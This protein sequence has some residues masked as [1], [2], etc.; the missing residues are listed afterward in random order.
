MS[1]EDKKNCSVTVVDTLFELDVWREFPAGEPRT[2]P[3]PI[4]FTLSLIDA[5]D[6]VD[7]ADTNYSTDAVA[8]ADLISVDHGRVMGVMH[9]AG[10]ARFFNQSDMRKYLVPRDVSSQVPSQILAPGLAR[11]PA[12]M[13]V[14][15]PANRLE[16]TPEN[17]SATS[18]LQ[19]SSQKPP[20]LNMLIEQA[21]AGSTVHLDEI[22]VQ[23]QRKDQV[24]TAR[25]SV[26]CTPIINAALQA[27]GVAITCTELTSP[28]TIETRAVG[29]IAPTE[30]SALITAGGG[31]DE[32][33]RQALEQQLR[34]ENEQ[35]RDL[36]DSFSEAFAFIAADWRISHINAEGLR[37]SS[38]PL[39]S[40]I[41]HDVWEVW[42]HMRGTMV[43]TEFERVMRSG[44]SVNFEQLLSFAGCN[45]RW[46]DIRIYPT[47]RGGLAIFCRDIT[48][49]RDVQETLREAERQSRSSNNYLRLLLDTMTEGLCALDRSMKVTMC[50]T[51]LVRMFGFDDISQVIGCELHEQIHYAHA[52][53]TPYHR[54]DCR[55]YIAARDGASVSIDDEVFFRRDGASFPV[56]YRVRPVWQDGE[57]YG[58]MCT[59]CDIS[60]RKRS[61][62]AL[63]ESEQ[64]FRSLFA[65]HI[66]AILAT[67]LDGAFYDSNSMMHELTGYSHE[68]LC[69]LKIGDLAVEDDAS[70]VRAHFVLAIEGTSQNFQCSVRQ[71]NGRLLR[72]EATHIPI[73]IEGDVIGIFVVIRDVTAAKNY[74]R[75]IRY[76]ASHDALTGLP[77]RNLLDDRLRY[78]I[79]QRG[80]YLVGVLFLDLNRFKIINDSLGHDKGDLL[81]QIVAGRMKATLR[82]G[83][84]IARLGG[85]EFVVV[86]DK[87]EAPEQI[88]TTAQKL[89]TEVERS[90]NLEGHDVS[91]STSIGI[92]V[93]PKDGIDAD[94]LLKHA[95][96]AMYQAKNAGSGTFRFFSPEM[97][98]KTLERLL[99]ETGLRRVID[100]NELIVHYQPRINVLTGETVGVEAL[101]R[102][103]HPERGLIAPNDFIPLA[104]EIGMIG[105]IGE[106]VLRTACHQNREWQEAGLPQTKMSINLSAYQLLSPI[107][108]DTLAAI[109]R[110]S[111][112]DVKWIELEITETGLMQNIDASLDTLGKIH[113]MGISMSIDDFGTGYSS[114]SY[115]KKL[116][117]NTLKIDQSFIR[118]L[119]DQ[120]DDAV[121]VAATIG[122]AH[123]MGLQVVAEGVAT[124]EQAQFL[125]EKDCTTMQGYLFSKPLSA[126]QCEL[127]LRR[128]GALFR[129]PSFGLPH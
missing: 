114:L 129:H 94:T 45:D 111:G 43:E 83:D 44:Q 98:I 87:I 74:E 36:F 29:H 66:D 39:A 52:D 30:S 17:T 11:E 18:S 125:V 115:L 117:V 82:Q 6:A 4:H 53:G 40:V 80:K 100:R 56:E 70:L 50:N 107:F 71:K 72:V 47:L 12:N 8:D 69:A 15:T 112:L 23:L 124:I 3:Q 119:L 19:K 60:E 42:P 67:R 46:Y 41:G 127:F 88:A 126:S 49:H 38:H 24:T 92:A 33:V 84:T 73:I 48:P 10:C 90:I 95:D 99:N 2:W 97:N 79:N 59:F 63:K 54:D 89:L 37:L 1:F 7:A 105:A 64:H 110:D 35:S 34:F 21:R 65:H 113:A 9:G 104:E 13:P 61:E 128:E 32:L 118:D 58:A 120:P 27:C 86:L 76:L 14:N 16:S 121:I 85:D 122:L 108:V 57:L 5:V 55:M 78:A 109:V 96:L 28:T 25:F 102:W 68:E 123:S 93:F 62:Q 77:N 91:I 106:W 116:P 26:T 51:A 81:L 75:H 20:H 101:V 31:G 22:S 103:L